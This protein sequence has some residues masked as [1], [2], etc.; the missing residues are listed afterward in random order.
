MRQLLGAAW[1]ER[2]LRGLAGGVGIVLLAMA[3]GF[4]VTPELL[5]MTQLA[6]EPARAVGINSLRGDFGGLFLGMGL[7]GVLGAATRHRWLLLV[8]LVFLS[9][10]VAGRMISL[11][12]DD[13][14]LVVGR[15]LASE[16]G[17]IAVLG[18]ALASFRARAG[19]DQSLGPLAAL[20]D[21]RALA[22]VGLVAVAVV[23]G[24]RFQRSM[25]LALLEA[26]S[27]ALLND[28]RFDR[29]PDG[30]HVGLAGTGAPLPD[31]RRRGGSSFVKAGDHL[32]IVDI[33]PGST[34]THE[35]MGV[36]LAEAE[37]VLLT[38]LHSDHMGGL[39]ELLLKAWT[40][41]PRTEPMRVLGPEGVVPLVQGFNLAYTVDAG[42][43][44]AHHGDLV[45]PESG[46]GG[47]PE[48]LGP[49]GDDEAV[50]VFQD[51]TL[52]V[53]AFLV[54]H[55]PA[56]PAV[57]YRFDYKGR[58]A[59]ISGDTLP[60]ENLRRHAHGADLL[61]H[62]VLQPEVLGVLH[63]TAVREGRAAAAKLTADI[64][65]YHTFPE[66]VARIARDEEV[67]H[68]VFH[69]FLPALPLR[70]LQPAFVGDARAI[71]PGPLTVGAEGM[72][73]SLAPGGDDVVLG[74]LL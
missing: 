25:G 59:V 53:T 12:V 26:S 17:F 42:Y 13:V 50:V 46:F 5:A 38:H 71:T 35:A 22:V 8:P 44:I 27:S 1:T 14:P 31:H 4:F 54:D 58:S 45:A 29:L 65:D 34:L 16:I 41:G 10:I 6:A 60:S 56:E 52:T 63:R 73:F 66:E 15:A 49:F 3:V 55:R 36:P 57:G 51:D 43:R 74:W 68:V 61:V 40:R 69:H 2:V 9:G 32:F 11:A 62:E 28:D 47:A 20:V 7:F 18:L 72:V 24:L 64:V 33:G 30:L 70:M 21:L 37:A 23:A 48:T 39:G 19:R 67:G